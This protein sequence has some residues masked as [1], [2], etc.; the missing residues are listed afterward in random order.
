MQCKTDDR[1]KV[2]SK[3]VHW[4]SHEAHDHDSCQRLRKGY[5]KERTGNSRSHLRAVKTKAVHCCCRHWLKELSSWLSQYHYVHVHTANLVDYTLSRITLIKSLLLH[6][7]ISIQILSPRNV[8]RRAMSH[9]VSFNYFNE[10]LEQ[11]EIIWYL[12]IILW[13]C[14]FSSALFNANGKDDRVLVDA[15]ARSWGVDWTR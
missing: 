3:V 12:W 5:E 7:H 8:T 13:Y 2:L 14:A 11:R 9:R 6:S 4:F 1:R 15:G 10:H